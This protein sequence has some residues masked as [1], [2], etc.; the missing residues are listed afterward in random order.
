MTRPLARARTLAHIVA[1]LALAALLRAAS[2]RAVPPET[3]S[4]S[5]ATGLVFGAYDPFAAAPLDSTSQ[6]VF[7]CTPAPRLRISLDAGGSGSF[8]A[9]ELRSGG[10]VLRYNL[11]LDAARTVVWGDGT[12]GSSVG[13]DVVVRGAGGMTTAYVF[14]R[15]AAGQ[16]PA[17][18]AYTDTIRV[19]FDF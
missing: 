4:V 6:L 14:G 2:A 18:G 11:Y 16:D 8:G 10:E 5:S 1:L 12:G 3:C 15:I 7:Q 17:P 9:R 13:P 19:T